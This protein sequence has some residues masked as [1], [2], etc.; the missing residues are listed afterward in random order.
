MIK[1]PSAFSSLKK[2]QTS[3]FGMS[4]GQSSKL[5]GGNPSSMVGNKW[6]KAGSKLSNGPSSMSFTTDMLGAE[7]KQ[8]LEKKIR[9]ICRVYDTLIR[10]LKPVIYKEAIEFVKEQG[11]QITNLCTEHHHKVINTFLRQSEAYT[12]MEA[13][14]Q[15]HR[16]LLVQQD[17]TVAMQAPCLEASFALLNESPLKLYDCLIPHISAAQ[18]YRYT[19]TKG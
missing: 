9:Q 16:D 4:F 18:E 15:R 2:T 17:L 8:M 14:S 5:M 6:T 11:I 19:I 12:S 7:V 1:G 3:K 10:D 13:Q